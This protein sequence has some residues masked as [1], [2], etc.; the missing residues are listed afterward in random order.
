MLWRYVLPPSSGYIMS[1]QGMV[2]LMN[3]PVNVD[4]T[5]QLP[6]G[7]RYDKEEVACTLCPVVSVNVTS[8]E[9]F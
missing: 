9:G 5:M 8:G 1:S 4:S 6:D 7:Q 2:I 3:M